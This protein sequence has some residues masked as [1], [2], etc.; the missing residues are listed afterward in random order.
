MKFCQRNSIHLISDEVYA[1]SV[2]PSRFAPD[3]PIFASIL[4]VDP[5]NL[6]DVDRI[7]VFY[8]FSKDFGAAGGRPGSLITRNALLRKAVS[9]NTRFH[10]L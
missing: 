9:S 1:L 10:A 7:H 5:A 6:I 3:A 8:G 4:S 2:Y